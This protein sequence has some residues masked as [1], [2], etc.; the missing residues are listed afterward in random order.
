[1]A[2]IFKIFIKKNVK[3]VYDAHELET[4]KSK[5]PYMNLV[6]KLIE[7][8]LIKYPDSILV[9]GDKIKD[10]YQ[11]IYGDLQNIA[12]IRNIPAINQN[13]VMPKESFLKNKFGLS[14][15]DI[16]FI[17]QG[18]LEKNRGIEVL[19]RVFSQVKDKHVVFMG[20]GSMENMIKEF[21]LDNK[22]I[23]F[24]PA[25]SPRDVLSYTS[26]ADVGFSILDNSC[27][28]HYYCLPNK[29]F[30]YI[31]AGIPVIA[32]NFPELAKII[33]D[34]GLGWKV[35]PNEKNVFTLINNINKQDILSKRQH[36]VAARSMFNWNQEARKLIDTYN[37]LIAIK[38]T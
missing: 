18:A 4:E 24:H 7:K 8:I 26:G 1:L 28:N 17:Y 11:M 34:Y 6:Y 27:L 10:H 13:E 31:L 20:F 21:S 32:S 22:N 2:V 3:I 25:I 9:V 14:S 30:E 29:F 16:L 15:R 23:H 37:N 5:K 12:V 38:N 35:L 36:A 19:L 33:D